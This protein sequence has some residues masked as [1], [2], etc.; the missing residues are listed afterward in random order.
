LTTLRLNPLPIGALLLL[1]IWPAARAETVIVAVATNFAV[2]LETLAE[3]FE[4]GTHH[5][6]EIRSG[7]TGLLYAQI[8]NGAPL[9]VF[10]A[11][12]QERPRLLVEERRAEAGSRLTYAEGRLVLFTADPGYR[13]GLGLDVLESAEFRWLAIATPELAPYGA[14]AE[15]TLRALGRWDALQARL[16][17]GNNIGATFAMAATGNAELAFVALSQA[18]TFDG[19]GAYVLV[20]DDLYAP[21]R[22]DAVLLTHAADNPAARAF[23]EFLGGAEARAIVESFGY[24]APASK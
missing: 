1:G 16:V 13:D 23:L 17:R 4:A 12:D 15:E 11:A 5:E 20:P 14:A 18:Q 2:P 8:V 7:S 24:R 9:D 22:Q 3:S 6:L 19:P 10:L 21:I